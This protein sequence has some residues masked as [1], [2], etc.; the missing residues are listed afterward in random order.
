MDQR[1]ASF[2]LPALMLLLGALPSAA[3]S[4]GAI[5]GQVTGLSG[6]AVPGAKVIV[7]SV[8]TGIE[9]PTTTTSE[10]YYSVPSL[11]PANYTVSAE[12]AGPI[13][14]FTGKNSA[15]HPAGSREYY[16]AQTYNVNFGVF[17]MGNN[18]PGRT[19]SIALKLNW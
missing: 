18:N 13:P 3:Q 2:W 10:G 7:T 15:S 6:A 9:R 8:E 4:T 12:I 17:N 1:R 16:I 14:Y 11:P 19:I 5:V